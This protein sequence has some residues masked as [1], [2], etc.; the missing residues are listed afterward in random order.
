M[1]TYDYVCKKCGFL[2]QDKWF[3]TYTKFRAHK[4]PECGGE[5]EQHFG[6]S[7]TL[8]FKIN[9]YCHTNEYKGRSMYRDIGKEKKTK[10][11]TKRERVC[12]RQLT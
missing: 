6:N 4:C 12:Q 7:E 9:G 3:Q 8:R 11:K 10:W 5:V 1:P 2:E